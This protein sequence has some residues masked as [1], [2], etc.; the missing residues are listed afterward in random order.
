MAEKTHGG[1]APFWPLSDA[2]ELDQCPVILSISYFS[3]CLFILHSEALQYHSSILLLGVEFS[4]NLSNMY[5]HLSP[6]AYLGWMGCFFL[7]FH[8]VRVMYWTESSLL[9]TATF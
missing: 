6:V 9:H 4:F 1:V 5:H 2:C 3:S 8:F 7:L